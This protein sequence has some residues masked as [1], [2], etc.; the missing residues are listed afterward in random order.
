MTNSEIIEVFGIPLT[1]LYDWQ[2]E[3][4]AKNKL[5][6]LLSH[7]NKEVAHSTINQPEETYRI[8]HILNKNIAKKYRYTREEK[9]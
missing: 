5:Y 8:F 1:T 6:R 3:G 9:R 7:I 4:H 2:K